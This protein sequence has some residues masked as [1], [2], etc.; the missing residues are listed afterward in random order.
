MKEKEMSARMYDQPGD[1]QCLVASL[2]LYLSKLH[3]DNN[4][5]F[6]HPR[7]TEATWKSTDYV[8]YRNEPICHNHLATL[9]KIMCKDAKLDTIYTNH[10]IRATI[11]TSP[12]KHISRLLQWTGSV[13]VP[14]YFTSM[15]Q[16]EGRHQ[17]LLL[18]LTSQQLQVL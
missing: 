11:A 17:N 13:L 12:C 9:M 16:L 1:P 4:A 8:W 18:L 7:K 3:P 14:A 15:G 6:Q 10:S 5:F 2:K